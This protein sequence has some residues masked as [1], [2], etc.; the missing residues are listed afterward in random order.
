MKKISLL[1]FLPLLVFG[2]PTEQLQ[3]D[4]AYVDY[5]MEVSDQMELEG[6]MN[7][8]E[9]KDHSVAVLTNL[10]IPVTYGAKYLVPKTLAE[11][12]IPK[13]L[14]T[15]SLSEQRQV[16]H[17]SLAPQERLDY[18]LAM[19]DLEFPKEDTLLNGLSPVRYKISGFGGAENMPEGFGFKIRL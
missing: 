7:N 17:R 1:L 16:K 12:N 6:E 3:N 18:L 2:Q 8:H 15:F 11:R 9:P 10:K 5:E 4:L 19:N 13:H 14:N